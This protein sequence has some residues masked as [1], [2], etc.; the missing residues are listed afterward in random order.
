LKY[1]KFVKQGM[2][3][4]ITGLLVCSF[5]GSSTRTMLPCLISVEAKNKTERK[6]ESIKETVKGCNQF[7]WSMFDSMEEENLFY[8]PYSI[9][10]ALSMLDN[11]ADK[12][13]KT[14][15][16]QL[17]NIKNLSSR[18]Q[19]LKKIMGELKNQDTILNTANSIWY[20][21]DDK[22]R[23]HQDMKKFLAPLSKYYNAEAFLADF[24][25]EKTVD[26]INQWISR[27][28]NQ[29][30]P[31]MLDDLDP[32]T[33]MTLINAVYFEGY[34]KKSFDHDSTRPQ[35]FYGT[36]KSNSVDM[37]H[38]YDWNLKFYEE[39]GLCAVEL[40]YKNS[41]LSMQIVMQKDREKD[42]VWNQLKKMSGKEKENLSKQI[43]DA[44][45][46]RINELALPKFQMNY[47]FDKLCDILKGMG[48][49]DSFDRTAADFNKIAKNLYVSDISHQ[50]K[51]EV[52]EA[53]SRAA[54]ATAID[55]VAT[56]VPTDPITFIVDHPFFYMIRDNQSGMILF[57]G[58]V[59][60]L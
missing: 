11:G 37:M 48:M 27:K 24:K 47:T 2:A 41:R 57:I 44:K 54:A 39:D 9:Q 15:L 53:G 19:N 58:Y 49:K 50:A 10:M 56:C 38:G 45:K 30:I 43:T 17:L 3:A 7:A 26:K 60:Q 36:H 20:F 12:Q 40:P 32:N 14:E 25:N 31:K 46:V 28:T 4:L 34:W 18:N 42:S 29:M 16:E 51:I 21:K 35:T 8:S 52:D 1:K 55:C 33:V 59:N 22:V 6:K 13:T 23:Y 5:A